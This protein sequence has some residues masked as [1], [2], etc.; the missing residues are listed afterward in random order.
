MTWPLREEI[1]NGNEH[2]TDALQSG[3][4]YG[5]EYTGGVVWNSLG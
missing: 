4:L 2:H 5:I 1:G 3:Q